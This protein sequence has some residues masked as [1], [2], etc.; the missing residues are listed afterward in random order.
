MMRQLV[1]CLLFTINGFPAE[2]LKDEIAPNDINIGKRNSLGRIGD[3]GYP[4]SP[5]LDRAKGYLLKGKVQNAVSNYGNF[6][7]WDYHPAGLWNNFAYLPHVGFVAGVPGH[8]YSSKWSS[9]SYNSWVQ[10]NIQVG[11]E[12]IDV[13]VSDDVYNDW[14]DGVDILD[15]IGEF[16]GNF[17]GVVYNTVDDR[18]D[19]AVEKTSI[20]DFVVDDDAQWVLDHV[21]EK[22]ILYLNDISLNPNFANSNIGI[23]YPWGIRPDL[24]ERTSEFDKFDYGEDLEEWTEDD[25]YVYYGATFAES[26]F[27]R[28]NGARLTDWQASTKSRF[29]SHTLDNTAGELFGN[30]S[31]TD[32]G[33]PD[34]V[35]AHSA[36]A[37]TWPEKYNVETGN[38]EKFWPGWWADAYYGESEGSW[39][40]LGITHCDANRLDEDCWKSIKGT[41]ISDMDVYMEFDDR[42]AHLGNQ[43]SN[44]KYEQTGYPMGLKVKS[45]AHSYGISYA[46]D[47]MFVTVRVR[48]ESG[49]FC[50][51]EKDKNGY[52][53]PIFD[54]DGNVICDEGMIMPDGTKLNRFPRDGGQVGRGFDY[55]GLYL[56]FYM[57]ADVLSTDAAGNFNVHTNDDDYMRYIECLTSKDVYPDGCPEVQGDKLRISMA[58][59]GDYDGI[60]NAATGYSMKDDESKGLDFGIVAVQLLDSPYA[61]EPIDLDQDGFNDIY[62]G[63]KLK[64]TDWH[65]FDWYNRPGVVSAESNSNCCAGEPGR[66][67]ARNK[68]L[69]QYKVISGDNTNLSDFEK[70]AFFHTDYPDSDLE[71]ELNP[72]F[73]SLEGLEQ[74]TFFK[75]GPDG[76]DCVLEMSTGPFD[77]E[78]GETVS[79]SFSI[80]YGQNIEDLKLNAKFAQIMY[81]SHYQ[82]YTAP[83]TPELYARTK[84]NKVELYWDDV[85]ETSVDVITGYT[86]FEGYKIYKSI[87]GGASWGQ[88]EDEIVIENVSVGWQ[89]YKQFDLSFAADSAFNVTPDTIR[90]TGISGSDPLTPWFNLGDNGGFEQVL[91]D[92]N[93]WN[94]L[95]DQNCNPDSVFVCDE[96]NN[97]CGLNNRLLADSI[98]FE[99]TPQCFDGDGDEI[100]SGNTSVYKYKYV[101][102]AVFDGIEYTYSIVAYDI[103]VMSAVTA[104]VDT[105]DV[106]GNM[107]GFVPVVISIPDP[108][109]WGL[110]NSFQTLESA[111]GTTNQDKNYITVIPGYPPQSNL[112]NVKV[113]PNPYIVHSKYNEKLYMK[114]IRFTRLPEKCT[115]TIF[116]ITGEKV[117][118]LNHY[119]QIDGNELWNLRSYN[120]QEVAPGLYI[121]VVETPGGEKLID[122]FAIVR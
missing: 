120:N 85:A 17:A 82:G 50:A 109:K 12:S 83:K 121:Y 63:D 51:F 5:Q 77:L 62:P 11:G 44:N 42:W 2:P 95:D 97:C 98:L 74:T 40:E 21:E 118:E 57:D 19:I 119:D 46:E 96:I 4:N 47:I 72:H 117:Q 68:E 112:K 48:N 38:F 90:G 3:Y 64:M 49:D 73:D 87:D 122:K 80:I 53:I 116:T 67:Q 55:K 94:G 108:D 93:C 99:I 70:T 102:D 32:P 78:V 84:H 25:A 111:K 100:F 1:I 114:Q 75:E 33:D 110:D 6:I 22:I 16:E 43:V 52:A 115:I 56:G 23:A 54:N 61:T 14:M 13:W 76:L 71:S 113:V 81:N 106:D 79:F 86:D 69:I 8:V 37:T 101:D 31:F 45:M 91:L 65:W 107:I 103:G 24:K 27:S 28:D 7:T 88:P 18:G 30:T 41:H 59:I 66:A 35:L 36:L 39:P 29:N 34:A 26:W 60:S 89:P 92:P 105:F 20:A 9:V 58:I 104:Y 15:A 10:E